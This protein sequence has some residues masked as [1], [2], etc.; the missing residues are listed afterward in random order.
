MLDAHQLPPMAVIGACIV[1]IFTAPAGA[2]VWIARRF[3]FGFA[4]AVFVLAAV[5]G[6]VA[7]SW[8][9]AE[10]FAQADR[11]ADAPSCTGALNGLLA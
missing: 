3:G 11:C 10:A 6:C 9:A 4:V 5:L 2:V 8:I 1:L 7:F